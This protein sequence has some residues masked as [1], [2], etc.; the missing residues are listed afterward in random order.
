MPTDA[1][2]LRAE[3]EGWNEL[4]GLAES[5]TPAEAMRP[6]Y[7]EEG[8]SV[9]DVLGH[10]GSWLAAAGAVLERIRAGTHRPEEVDVDEWNAGFLEAMRDVP[11]ADVRA[12]AWAARTRMLQA[13]G[14]L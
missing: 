6:G 13:W 5:L 12:Q 9:R 14:E 8:W 4:H 2:L 3:D 1:D 11:L 10:V 7:F